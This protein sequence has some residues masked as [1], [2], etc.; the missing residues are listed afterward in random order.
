L[1]S[2]QL[3]GSLERRLCA[4]KRSYSKASGYAVATRFW[5]VILLIIRLGSEILGFLR[6]EHSIGNGEVDSYV[7]TVLGAI[8]ALVLGFGLMALMFY[9]NRKG[10]DESAHKDQTRPHASPELDHLLDRLAGL[11]CFF[12]I[13]LSVLLLYRCFPSTMAAMVNFKRPLNL[14]GLRR[15]TEADVQRMRETSGPLERC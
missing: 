13:S 10:Y 8:V 6:P 9:S 2:K 14:T 3:R 5:H 12:A 1:F 4:Q 7:A 15:P 11:C